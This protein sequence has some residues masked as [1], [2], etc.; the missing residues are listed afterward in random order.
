MKFS[1]DYLYLTLACTFLKDLAVSASK[2][3]YKILGVSR[4]ASEREVKKAFRK[5]AVKY[6]PDKNKEP[7]AEKKFRDIAEAH[8]VLSDEKKR[9]I[10]DQYGEAG[11]KDQ[12]GFDGSSF[13]FN[14]HDFFQDFPFSGGFKK[15][16]GKSGGGGRGFFSDFFDDD[17][18]FQEQ[19]GDSFFGNHFGFNQGHSQAQDRFHNNDG[20]G[21]SMQ[22]GFGENMFGD[23]AS[24]DSQATF[25]ESSYSSGGRCKTV[26][27]KV[28]NMVMTSTQCS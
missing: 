27:K 20:F 11:L 19:Q 17:E 18:D 16:S 1:L 8:E 15:Q 9:R 10:Y 21:D 28:G 14:F 5:L 3:Y 25:S 26:T 6:H 7:D 22:F 4:D 13:D 2:D 24:M 23:F 12:A